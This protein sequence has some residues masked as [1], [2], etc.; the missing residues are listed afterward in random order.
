MPCRISPILTAPD[1]IRQ[2]SNIRKPNNMRK[3]N[4]KQGSLTRQKE[5]PTQHKEAQHN[6]R[7]PNAGLPL[8][9]GLDP[10]AVKLDTLSKRYGNQKAR[11]SSI[12]DTRTLTGYYIPA[13]G[14]MHG[15]PYLRL[16][17]TY[18]VPCPSLYIYIY[19][20]IHIHE[21]IYIYMSKE[22]NRKYNI[23]TYRNIYTLYV[24]IQ[25]IR[26]YIHVYMYIQITDLT[27]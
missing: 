16:K 1:K 19:T 18:S 10:K 12:A 26:I 27:Y 25:Y 6:V 20:D 5:A 21:N 15:S 8:F 9:E 14:S 23:Y 11:S 4:T 7:T 13:L 2:R 24:H 3:P 17:T 22:I